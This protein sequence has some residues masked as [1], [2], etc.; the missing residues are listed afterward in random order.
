MNRRIWSEDQND[1]LELVNALIDTKQLVTLQCKGKI[2]L[3]TKFIRIHLHNHIPYLLMHKPA[4]IVSSRNVRDLFFKMKGLP[5]L[6]FSCP[7]TRE[8]DTVLATM[9]PGSVFNLDLRDG[10]ERFCPLDGSMATFFV[11]DRSKA[12]ICRMEDISI[13]GA[14]LIGAPTQPV[15]VNDTIGP[16]TLSLAGVDALISRE[17]TVNKATVVREI[18]G[19][20]NSRGGMGI[21]FEFEGKEEIQMKEQ[22]ERLKASLE[23]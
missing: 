1:I 19:G 5:I 13:G 7:I 8:G 4:E 17:V 2:R 6:G 12:S 11:R 23:N 15:R 20:E 10:G 16:C 18:V 9:L 21:Q 14:K 22:L 3:K